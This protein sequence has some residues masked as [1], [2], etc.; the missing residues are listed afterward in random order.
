MS[1]NLA[2]EVSLS[3]SAGIFNMPQNLPY[4]ANGFD[5]PP[6]EVVLRIFVALKIHRPRQGYVENITLV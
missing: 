1:L 6:K 2:D 3:Y 4:E 5:S